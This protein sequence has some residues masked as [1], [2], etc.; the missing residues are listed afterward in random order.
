MSTTTQPSTRAAGNSKVVLFL[1]WL[2]VGL[3]LI[4]GVAQTIR[5]ALVL[6]H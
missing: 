1:A 4:W 6:F 5:K 3:P 2:A